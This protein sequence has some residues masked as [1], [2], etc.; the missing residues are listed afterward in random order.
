M[1]TLFI[2]TSKPPELDE[3]A[4]YR[5]DPLE[6]IRLMKLRWPYAKV[7]FVN[8]EYY[9]YNWELNQHDRLGLLGGLQ[10]NRLVVSFNSNP[11][12]DVIEFILWH[13]D[14]VPTDIP[15]FLFNTNLGLLYELRPKVTG[16]DL[17]SLF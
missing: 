8:N 5:I 11:H 9:E 7:V 14:F 10:S 13:R 6:Y 17:A 12:E 4:N 2:A 1:S 16:Q 15:L 3:A